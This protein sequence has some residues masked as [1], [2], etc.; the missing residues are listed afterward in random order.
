M[1]DLKAETKQLLKQY[2]ITPGD[3]SGQNFLIDVHVLD[4]IISTANI[5]PTDNVLEIGPGLGTLTTELTQR[6]QQVVSVEFDRQLMPLLSKLETMH[7]NL[8]LV[9]QD[10]LQISNQQLANYFKTDKYRVIAN[11]PYHITSKIIR[12]FLTELPK[13]T[14]MVLMIQQE[15]AERIVARPGEMSLLAVSV[16]LYAQAEIVRRVDKSSF[17]PQPEVNSAII[18]IQLT[19]KYLQQL[20][21]LQL[22]HKNFWSVVRAGFAAKRKTL[23]NNLSSSFKLDKQ[24][25]TQILSEL[26][27]SATV[28][29][30]ELSIDEWMQLTQRLL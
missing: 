9:Q 17:W 18:H 25:V 16:Q 28:R 26:D 6:A 14:D 21:Q 2:K 29:A 27:L 10:I 1:R 30:Q 19:D 4:S 24:V 11:I 8:Q 5:Q 22:T 13:P 12:K 3:I 23:I 20:Q 7:Q 15:V